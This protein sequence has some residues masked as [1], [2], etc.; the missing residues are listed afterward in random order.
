[1]VE[2]VTRSLRGTIHVA[3]AFNFVSLVRSE[4]DSRRLRK[5]WYAFIV[6]NYT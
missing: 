1:M 2:P 3:L 5:I 6:V 4:A